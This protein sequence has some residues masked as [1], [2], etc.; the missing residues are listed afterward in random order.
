MRQFLRIAASLAALAF[1]VMS[2]AQP[3]AAQDV[4]QIK[5]T[6]KQV[7]GFI[8]AQKDLSAISDKLQDAGDKP[9]AALEAELESIAKKHGFQS[10]QELDDVAANVSIVMAG[11]DPQSGEFTDPQVALKKELADIKADDTIPAEE[12]KQLIEELNEAIQTTPPL[13]HQENIEVVKKH[14]AEIEAALQ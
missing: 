10:F 5:L 13:Q 4:T 8:A 7:L 1:V 12:K 9:D 14:R 3:A 6:E 2:F 11:L